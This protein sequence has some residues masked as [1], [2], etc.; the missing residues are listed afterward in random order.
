MLEALGEVLDDL[1]EGVLVGL[2]FFDRQPPPRRVDAKER[3]RDV[4]ALHESNASHGDRLGSFAGGR[5][6]ERM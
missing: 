6:K 2:A 1:G 4:L 3:V 5:G